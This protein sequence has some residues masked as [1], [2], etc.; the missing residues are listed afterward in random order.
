M[1][2]GRW[3]DLRRPPLREAALRRVLL[4]PSGPLGRLDVVRETGSTNADLVAA[5]LRDPAEWPDLS[6]L[7]ADSQTAGRGRLGRSWTTPPGSALAVSVLVHPP[8]RTSTWSWLP[9]LAGLAVVEAVGSAAGL[10]AGLKWPNDV[11]VTVDGERRK[12]CGVLTEVVPASAGPA[13]VVGL[14]LNVSQTLD[15]LTFPSATSLALAGAATT[16]RDTLL[17]AVLRAFASRYLQW[18]EDGVDAGLSARVREVCWTLGEPVLVTLPGGGVLEGL[19]E[20]LDADGRLVVRSP[21]GE[22]HP[23]AA[24]DVVHARVAGG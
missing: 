13:V 1:E 3:S 23:V 16:D 11:L 7:A 8:W 12:V 19:A 10:D 5:A 2:T 21:D 15:E 18:R 24:G 9:L 22:L 14:G 20:E 17:R 6:V 4:A